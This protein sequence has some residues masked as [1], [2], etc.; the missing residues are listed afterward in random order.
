MGTAVAAVEADAVAVVSD[1]TSTGGGLGVVATLGG[2]VEISRAQIDRAREAGATVLAG[3]RVALTDVHIHDVVPNGMITG[4]GAVASSDAELELSRVLVERVGFGMIAGVS[5][6]EQ[7]APQVTADDLV[8]RETTAAGIDLEAALATLARV[9]I[10]RAGDAGLVAR[11]A[12]VDLRVTDL[13][14]AD[15]HGRSSDG[16]LGRGIHVASGA[17]MRGARVTVAGALG[18]GLVATDPGTRVDLDHVWIADTAEESCAAS[19]AE[20]AAGHGVASLFE[21]SVALSHVRVS[22]SAWAGVLVSDGGA[23]TLASGVVDGNRVGRALLQI[24]PGAFSMT[25]VLFDANEV[26][27]VREGVV[28]PSPSLL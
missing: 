4:I 2:S 23:L 16:R 25:D 11:N 10:E 24:V 28:V 6:P 12:S 9:R 3:S 15:L 26:D 27:E 18:A 22:G 8:I 13:A 5:S 14:I 20:R 1:L 19:C 17:G 7:P 21:A